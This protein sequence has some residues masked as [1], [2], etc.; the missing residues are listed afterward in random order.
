MPTPFPIPFEQS[1][2]P[3]LLPPSKFELLIAKMGQRV[4]WMQSHSCPCV[5][6]G[7]GANGQ[8]PFPGSAQRSCQRCFGTGTYWDDPTLPIQ[9]G[10]NFM[11]LSPT[12]DEPGA[13]MDGAFGV[14]QMAEPSLTIPYTNPLLAVN[15]PAQPT[16]VWTNA[17]LND[18]FIPIDM[19]SRYTA[20]LQ[21][22]GQVFLPY[23][24]NLQI[25]PSGAV[26]TWDA[27]TSQVVS[28]PNYTVSGAM[29]TVTGF[30]P[31]TNYMVEFQ[32]APMY[33]AFRPA[34][35]LPHVRQFGGGTANEPRRFKI[36]SLD[37]WTR[38]AGRQMATAAGNAK[39][40]NLSFPFAVMFGRVVG[41]T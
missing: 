17:S 29:V 1:I 3:Y 32:A 24:Q 33:V 10:I 39:V 41:T 27:S 40:G 31:G 6:A 38:Q 7:G 26:T 8:L 18:I 11:Q 23:Q 13:R 36:Q 15:D 2:N 16:Q 22:S 28:V 34:G 21:V 37:F 12:P 35:G 19:L 25:A 5:F 4:S 20:V 9:M 30:P 14:H